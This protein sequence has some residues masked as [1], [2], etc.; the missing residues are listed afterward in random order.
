MNQ[1]AL[2]K[3]MH[4]I[5][6]EKQFHLGFLPTEQSSPLT[7]NMDKEFASSVPGGVRNLQSVDRNVAEMAKK[8]FASIEYRK[9]VGTGEKIIR[10]RH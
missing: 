6:N 3:A 2:E 1:T 8:M 9:L 10:H 7:V 4:F 5:E